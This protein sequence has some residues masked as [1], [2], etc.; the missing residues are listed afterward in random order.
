MKRLTVIKVVGVSFCGSSVFNL[1]MDSHS[2]IYGGGELHKLFH[3]TKV[4]RCSV[5]GTACSY[6]DSRAL[7]NMEMGSLYHSLEEMFGSRVIVDS[8]KI[9]SHFRAIESENEEVDSKYVLL[10]KHPLRHIASY[11]TNKLLTQKDWKAR[12]NAGR[13]SRLHLNEITDFALGKAAKMIEEYKEI[14]EALS[15]F[16]ASPHTVIRYEDF[17]SETAEIVESLL[18]EVELPFEGEM[19]RFEHQPHHPIGGNNGPHFQVNKSRNMSKSVQYRLDWYSRQ[20]GISVDNKFRR[21]FSE[22][23]IR[24]ISRSAVYQNLCDSL[25]YDDSLR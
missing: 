21:T 17:A 3:Q 8:S 16:T 15:E 25:G 1:V 10:T 14:R 24:D 12:V 6:W 23:Q 20:S 5:C 11:T 4:A 7:E 9:V 13:L 18:S 19:M 22:R 2:S